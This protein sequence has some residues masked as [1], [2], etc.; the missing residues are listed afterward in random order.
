M[1]PREFLRWTRGSGGK[2]F[3]FLDYRFGVGNV[4]TGETP[5]IE[6]T[7]KEQTLSGPDVLAVNTL[8]A[9]AENPRVIALRNFITGWHL[10]YLSADAARGN[11]ESGPEERLS[12]KVVTICLTSFNT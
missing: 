3:N 10:S 6:D 7:R 9:L 4:I 5:E 1:V 11:P 12:R 8:G 2:P